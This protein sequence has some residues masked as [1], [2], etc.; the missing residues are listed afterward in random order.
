M[1]KKRAAESHC[2]REGCE[3]Y[4][5]HTHTHKETLDK[6]DISVTF[7]TP[8]ARRPRNGNLLILR[9]KYF[10]AIYTIVAEIYRV[11]PVKFRLLNII[12]IVCA[13][14]SSNMLTKLP[15]ILFPIFFSRPFLFFFTLRL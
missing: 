3:T 11:P 8:T 1:L 15:L 6:T 5:R 2:A 7:R 12:L 10:T 9:G 14:K 4:T 13:R